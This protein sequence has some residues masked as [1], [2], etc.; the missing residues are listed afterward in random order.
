MG[1]GEEI[2]FFC[3]LSAHNETDGANIINL[4]GRYNVHM[5]FTSNPLMLKVQGKRGDLKQI[6]GY[7]EVFMKVGKVTRE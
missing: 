7:M 6:E 1:K 3:L 4:T 2:I 5:S